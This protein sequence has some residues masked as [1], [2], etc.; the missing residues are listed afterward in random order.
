MSGKHKNTRSLL[1]NVFFF[2]MRHKSYLQQE[3]NLAFEV[4]KLISASSNLLLSILVS[5]FWKLNPIKTNHL[6][7]LIAVVQKEVP[8]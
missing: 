8:L 4:R 6:K 2:V 7:N 5:F 3:I 1:Q